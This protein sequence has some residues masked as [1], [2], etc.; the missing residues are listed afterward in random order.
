MIIN[1][2]I[3]IP[4]AL[5]SLRPGAQWVLRGATVD[6]L[7]WIDTDQTQPTEQEIAD[8]IGRLQQE[9]DQTEYQRKRKNQYPPITDFADAMY[10][11]SRGDNSRL[12][13]YY[14]ACA[15]VKAQYPKI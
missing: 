13:A 1:P 14:A 9:F 10:W 11:A 2:I 7:E 8:E 5:Q 15:A 12:E 6:D 3:D 4:T